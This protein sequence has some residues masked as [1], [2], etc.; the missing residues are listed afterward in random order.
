[1]QIARGRSADTGGAKGPS[2]RRGWVL[3]RA[4]GLI[5]GLILILG[6]APG[7]AGGA[8]AV[9]AEATDL[10]AEDLTITL[11][12]LRDDG[13]NGPCRAS[14]RIETGASFTLA[15]FSM[16]LA[17]Y[18]RSGTMMHHLTVL[19]MPVEPEQPTQATFPA[20]PGAC[21]PIGAMRL[22]AFPLCGDAKGRRLSCDRAAR[23]QSLI[24]VPFER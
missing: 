20:S 10:A 21:A 17:L 14:V 11:N 15:T 4:P 3:C 22:L 19:A 2:W 12:A 18:D 9:A 6:L 24:D 7:P 13:G 1:M 5:L 8:P 23:T 16:R